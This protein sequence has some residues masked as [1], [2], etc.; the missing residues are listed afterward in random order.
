VLSSNV[1][2]GMASVQGPSSPYCLTAVDPAD[3]HWVSLP[4]TDTN[5]IVESDSK[6]IAGMT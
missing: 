1:K 5:H 4:L 2:F 6:T 3:G